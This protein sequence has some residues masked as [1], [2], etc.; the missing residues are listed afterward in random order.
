MKTG[1]E[2]IGGQVSDYSPQAEVYAGG[3]VP[4]EDLTKYD[5]GRELPDDP[6]ELKAAVAKLDLKSGYAKL[7]TLRD[8][9]E[10]LRSKS[11]KEA[12]ALYR[13]LQPKIRALEQHIYSIQQGLPTLAR[14]DAD[15]QANEQRRTR[16]LIPLEMEN[17]ALRLEVEKREGRLPEFQFLQ[18]HNG[19]K[20]TLSPIKRLLSEELIQKLICR[21]YVL[22][23]DYIIANIRADDLLN[24][25]E[26]LDRLK[27]E[28][29]DCLD[30]DRIRE[31]RV[32]V[33]EAAAALGTTQNRADVMA[34]RTILHKL[35]RPVVDE[36]I[37]IAFAA[38]KLLEA[39]H[40]EAIA[41]ETKWLAS[42]G[43]PHSPTP[44]S[45]RF[46]GEREKFA[47]IRKA[48]MNKSPSQPETLGSI[49]DSPVEKWFGIQLD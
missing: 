32:E 7:R 34:T 12:V 13:Q 1:H 5:D 44:V 31:L 39:Y 17:R 4:M 25:E 18:P 19:P 8:R 10:G 36:M 2:Q 23:R 15:Q 28:M 42:F 35:Y 43:L 38:E 22:R 29:A 49:K 24:P 45:K 3:I 6:N 14:A 16:V 30:L 9:A 40:A 27:R 21:Y 33:A 46:E 41:A 11:T 20:H 48:Y 37:G 26:R 47:D